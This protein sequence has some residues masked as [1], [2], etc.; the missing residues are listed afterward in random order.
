MLL[1]NAHHAH[2]IETVGAFDYVCLFAFVHAIAWSFTFDRPLLFQLLYVRPDF[3]Q[4]LMRTRFYDVN[5]I[6]NVFFPL[7]SLSLKL[8]AIISIRP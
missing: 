1:P 2:D 8:K 3:P 7:L 4:I 6:V 5:L